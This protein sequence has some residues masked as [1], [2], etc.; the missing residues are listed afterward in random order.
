MA[1]IGLGIVLLFVRGRP[2]R[3]GDIIH[4]PFTLL[5][6]DKYVCQCAQPHDRRGHGCRYN[7][8]EGG[9][10]LPSQSPRAG[11][12]IPLWTTDRMLYVV[13][14][15]FDQPAVKRVAEQKKKLPKR[16]RRFVA[17]CR[18]KLVEWIEQ[19]KVRFDTKDPWDPQIQNWR[20]E[21]VDCDAR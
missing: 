3:A 15:V 2:P 18:V 8:Y 14:G 21:V 12:W 17:Y 16:E 6:R 10:V 20:V 19:G 9:Q 5:P 7:L 13:E 11:T 4:T 1:S